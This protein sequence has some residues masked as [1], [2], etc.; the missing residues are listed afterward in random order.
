MMTCKIFVLSQIPLA[1]KNR[2]LS[3]YYKFQMLHYLDTVNESEVNINITLLLSTYEK[4]FT[5]F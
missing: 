1:I 2:L 5:H 4:I 3:Y